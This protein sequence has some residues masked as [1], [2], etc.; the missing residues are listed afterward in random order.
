LVLG[1]IIQKQLSN[2]NRKTPVLGSIPGLG[3]AFKKKDKT[4]QDVEL[5]VFLRPKITRSAAEARELL[6]EADKKAP[7]VRPWRGDI[8]PEVNDKKPAKTGA[9]QKN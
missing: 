8:L 2:T 7:L 6:E 5:L 1:G 4:T 3:W 9:E